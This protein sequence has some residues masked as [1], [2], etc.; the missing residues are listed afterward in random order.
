MHDEKSAECH[1]HY[2]LTLGSKI[3]NTRWRFYKA[4]TQKTFKYTEAVHDY[5][6]CNQFSEKQRACR[7][8]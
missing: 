5:K 4:Y 2:V 3:K 6:Q 8:F 7:N 1:I